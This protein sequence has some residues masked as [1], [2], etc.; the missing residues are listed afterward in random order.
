MRKTEAENLIGYARVSTTE[1]HLDMQ[2][3]ALAAAG[4]S[5]DNMHVEKVSGATSK[6]PMLEWA[7]DSLRP[8]DTLVVWKMDRMA[9][10]LSDLIARVQQ[11]E[12]AGAQFRSLTEQIDTSTPGGRL[13]FHVLGAIAEFERDLI[14]ERTRT[15]VK[16]AMARG[17]KFGTAPKLSPKQVQLAQK[18]RDQ[19]QS[20]RVIGDQFGVSHSTIRA[21]TVGPGRKRKK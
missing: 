20:I 15:G 13:V 14:R 10:S 2:I 11:I 7:L 12:A 16:A 18:L 4:V 8:G 17:V 6:R 19:G 9:R 21:W 5:R 1:Q 3:E